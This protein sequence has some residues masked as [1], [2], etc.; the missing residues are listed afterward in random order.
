[1]GHISSQKVVTR[2][3]WHGRRRL[4][5]QGKRE[6]FTAIEVI[7]A[8]RYSLPLCVIFKGKVAI[9]G[10]FTDN[11]PKDWRIEVSD[12]GWTTDEIGLRWLQK[13]S[14]Q[15]IRVYAVVFGY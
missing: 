14:H 11:L 15:Q 3:E 7:C 1:M 5:Q 13:I 12:N 10:L 8:D 9:A 4:L 6:W 2:A